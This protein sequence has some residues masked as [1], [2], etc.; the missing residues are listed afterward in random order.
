MRRVP[1]GSNEPQVTQPA[2]AARTQPSS[3][4]G[5][6][7]TR[8]ERPPKSHLGHQSNMGKCDF[9]WGSEVKPVLVLFLV[10]FLESPEL[11]PSYI[12]PDMPAANG[13]AGDSH[14]GETSQDVPS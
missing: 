13:L 14:P 11:R 7:G 12:L 2:R 5:E 1:R 10:F 4:Q 3:C 6:H 8:G 9:C